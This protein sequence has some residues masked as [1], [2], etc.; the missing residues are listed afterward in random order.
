MHKIFD[1]VVI[2]TYIVVLNKNEF[3]QPILSH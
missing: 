1:C 3:A 2:I